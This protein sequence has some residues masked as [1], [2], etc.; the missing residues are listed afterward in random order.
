MT[1]EPVFNSEEISFLFKRHDRARLG[2]VTKD[3][4]AWELRPLDL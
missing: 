2:R 3:D 1:K 4:L